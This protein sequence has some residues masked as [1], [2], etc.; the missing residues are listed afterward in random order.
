[1]NSYVISGGK[2]GK[3]RLSLLSQVM[4]PFTS[5][6]LSTVGIERGMQCLDLG[7]G[8]GDVTLLL[9]SMVDS[10]GQVIGIDND[11][12]ILELNRL[13]VEASQL[14]NLSF[15]WGDALNLK[16]E[17]LFDLVY[18]RFLITHLPQPEKCL[19]GMIR[20]CKPQGAI[21]IEDIDFTGSFCYPDCAAY[22]RYTEL[23]QTVVYRRGG[24]PTIG[25]KLFLLLRKAGIEKIQIN[26][27]QPIHIQG[28]G[29]LIAS[30]TMEKI[31]RAVVAEGLATQAEI[32]GIIQVLNCFAADPDTVMSL[33]RIIQV[34]GKKAA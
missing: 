15:H 6:F 14:T 23:Y 4:L 29:K 8:G 31:A 20:A 17:K 5:Q 1:M 32:E 2:D 26:V 30:I 27:V 28:E 33:P 3:E 7:C 34:W 9:A 12:D 11:H 25:S 18:A 22:K 19:E 13:D 21:A 24:D 10:P 16:V